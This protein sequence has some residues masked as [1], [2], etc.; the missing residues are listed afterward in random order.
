MEHRQ[1][2]KEKGRKIK[3]SLLS[4][5]PKKQ[6]ASSSTSVSDPGSTPAASHAPCEQSD[7]GME[8]ADS[9]SG[10]L[11]SS[12]ARRS[13]ETEGTTSD[14][15]APVDPRLAAA[16]L[17]VAVLALWRPSTSFFLLS[18]AMNLALGAALILQG[19][20]ALRQRDLISKYLQQNSEASEAIEGQEA[21]VDVTSTCGLQ[22]LLEP[23]WKHMRDVIGQRELKGILTH[24]ELG[25]KSPQVTFV[26]S[27]K[28]PCEGVVSFD[29]GLQ[30]LASSTCPLVQLEVP[31][32]G[33]SDPWIFQIQLLQLDL[34]AQLYFWSVPP[35]GRGSGRSYSLI[36]AALSPDPPKPPT[37]S[38]ALKAV[39]TSKVLEQVL[40]RCEHVASAVICSHVLPRFT[41]F[42]QRVILEEGRARQA[43]S[44]DSMAW[45]QQARR[46]G[47]QP[48]AEAVVESVRS[49]FFNGTAFEI[50]NM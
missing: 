43:D 35:E 44:K 33:Y 19:C 49:S 6:A 8:V 7:G 25:D 18:V 46:A 48:R 30:L 5:L 50:E 17:V 29:V 32:P 45:Q 41:G 3:A 21:E 37:V 42:D 1:S 14:Q 39:S 38:V 27:V 12:A 26:R 24:I 28:S 4:K 34:T 36:E 47:W 13:S 20:Y 2:L 15:S 31:V 16:I 10:E 9:V 22:Q 11:A 23:G 40:Y